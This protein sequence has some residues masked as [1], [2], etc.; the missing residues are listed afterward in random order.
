MSE[1]LYDED[2]YAEQYAQ[3]FEATSFAAYAKKHAQAAAQLSLRSDYEPQK[4]VFGEAFIGKGWAYIPTDGLSQ[5]QKARMRWLTY[6]VNAVVGNTSPDAEHWNQHLLR[7]NKLWWRRSE[8]NWLPLHYGEDDVRGFL[9]E[10]FRTA[11][12]IEIKDKEGEVV[13]HYGDGALPED[14]LMNKAVKMCRE[15]AKPPSMKANKLPEDRAE[16]AFNLL[17]GDVAPGIAFT[18]AR[19][20]LSQTTTRFGPPQPAVF[21]PQS[22]SFGWTAQPKPTPAWDK[23][24]S[25]IANDNEAIKHHIELLVGSVASGR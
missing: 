11:P 19:L 4:P 15:L 10:A 2:F 18:N 8:D 9:M 17:S 13:A 20:F 24:L 16:R 7:I 23:L 22:K 1:K 3:Q 21:Y 6:A 25:G 5:I 14:T 12:K